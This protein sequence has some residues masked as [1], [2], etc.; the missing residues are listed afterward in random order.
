MSDGPMNRQER[1]LDAA[2]YVIGTMTALERRA[3]EASMESDELARKDAEF[4]ER[5]FGVLNASVAPEIPPADMWSRIEAGLPNR[6]RPGA[7]ATASLTSAPS[8]SGPAN[9]NSVDI[10]RRS[11]GRWRMGAMAATI[12]ALGLG[13]YVYN[14]LGLPGLGQ[15]PQ[16]AQ[17]D[18]GREYVA[19]VNANGDQPSLIINIDAKTGDVTVRSVGVERPDGKSLELWY[20]PEGQKAVSVGLVGESGI[21]L[22]DIAAKRG[23]LLAISLEPQGGSPT[24]TATGPVMY[25][26]KLVEN[27]DAN[28]A[29]SE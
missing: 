23:D 4:W 1:Q 8:T 25:T 26:G 10:L 15:P 7:D 28:A 24:G 22:Q 9:D 19:V 14:D 2:E 16:L 6:G 12:A 5:S 18:D 27:V 21:D 17:S 11:R 29:K 3:F 20:V 13:A